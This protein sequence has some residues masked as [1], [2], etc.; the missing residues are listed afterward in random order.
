MAHDFR[1]DRPLEFEQYVCKHY[2]K[3]MTNIT[4]NKYKMY[5]T[6]KVIR[7][8]TKFCHM[9]LDNKPYCICER[10]YDQMDFK[11][12]DDDDIKPIKKILNMINN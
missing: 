11:I 4:Q 3:F 5:N 12:M 8:V 1:F 2:F 10:Y 7:Q 9:C 6:Q